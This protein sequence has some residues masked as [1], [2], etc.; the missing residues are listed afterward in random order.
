MNVYKGLFLNGKRHGYGVFQYA[1]GSKYD[2]EW[3]ENL[4]VL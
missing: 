2:G 4:K 3:S 1:N